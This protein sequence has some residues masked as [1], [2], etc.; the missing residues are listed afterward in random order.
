MLGWS[1][2]PDPPG[3][4]VKLPKRIAFPFG[5]NV[6]I[7]EVTDS[8]MRDLDNSDE[9][10]SD[11]CWDEKTRTIYIVKTLSPRRKRYILGHETIHAVLDWV[12]SQLNER[13]MKP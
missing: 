3:A 2:T 4:S 9:R 13:E 10:E 8:E 1:I 11:G 7:K 6:A 5:Y 12:H